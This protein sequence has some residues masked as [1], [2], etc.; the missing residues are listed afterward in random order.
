MKNKAVRIVVWLFIAFLAW[1]ALNSWSLAAPRIAFRLIVGWASFLVRVGSAMTMSWSG[2]GMALACSLLIV[3][4]MHSLSKWLYAHA[5]G[6]FGSTLPVGWR[7]SW[8]FSLYLGIWL[9]FMAIMGAVGVAHQ[10]GWL[11]RSKE[12]LMVQRKF[13]GAERVDLRQFALELHTAGEAHGWKADSMRKG[14]ATLSSEF[15]RRPAIEDYH[16]LLFGGEQGGVTSVVVFPRDPTAFTTVGFVRV[17]RHSD[18]DFHPAEALRQ[19]L[20]NSV[21]A[22]DSTENSR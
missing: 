8:T 19:F 22:M 1:M 21:A 13:R 20:A 7:W 16:M 3:A 17:S 5:A 14:F 18:I 6:R 11:V 10:V 15:T 9:I 2:I 4:G 12:P